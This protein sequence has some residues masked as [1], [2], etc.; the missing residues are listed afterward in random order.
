M[1]S[2]KNIPECYMR[3]VSPRPL[4]CFIALAIM[5][6]GSVILMRIFGRHIESQSFWLIALGVPAALWSVVVGGRVT[7]W[8][9]KDMKANGFDK[10]REAWILSETRRARRALQILNVS[11]TTGHLAERQS[12]VANE[13]FNNTRLIAAQ[14]NWVGT[15]G[16]RMSR[17]AANPND[18]PSS[19]ITRL[20]EQLIENLSLRLTLCSDQTSL[21][22]VFDISSTVPRNEVLRLWEAAWAESEMPF[23]IEYLGGTGLGVVENWLNVHFKESAMLVVVSLQVAP[24]NADNSAEAGVALL[25]GNRL[26]QE[27]LPPL[28]LL[29]RPDP[30]PAEE[31]ESGM[32]M[33]AYNVPINDGIVKHLWL[34][35]LNDQ[36]HAE[37]VVHQKKSPAQAVEGD[38]VI[39]LDSA[40]GHAGAA[41]P[42]LAIAAATEIAQRTQSPQ[43]IICGD[44]TQDVLWSTLVTPTASRKEMDS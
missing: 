12:D 19:L 4:R 30:S 10:C 24:E 16:L 8:M 27:V 13:I 6:A 9:L 17:I 28:A 44:I 41:A 26:T 11:F 43:M 33:A 40:M 29:H 34:S 15:E 7:I 2:L 21:S 35:G 23:P 37:V 3:P 5:L 22:V 42:W 1:Y 20:F 38:A 32:R 25:F 14:P 39:N 31:L 18:T 36:Q